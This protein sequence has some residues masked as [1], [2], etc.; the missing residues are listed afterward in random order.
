MSTLTG[1]A[2]I[3]ALLA[4]AT[5]AEELDRAR[6]LVDVE[7]RYGVAIEVLDR[8][9][10]DPDLARK[11]RI[12]AYRLL[13]VAY[14]AKGASDSAEAA[15]GALLELEPSYVLDPRLS[16]KIRSVFDRAKA[17]V[18]RPVRLLDVRALSS[19]RRVSVTARIE[20]PD[21]R[22]RRVRLY[23]RFGDRAFEA[24][25]MNRTEDRAETMLILPDLDRL[26]VEYYVEAENDAGEALARAGSPE[27]PSSV[28]LERQVDFTPPPPGTEPAVASPWYGEWW[29]WTIVAGV[30]G[31][32]VAA[33]VIAVETSKGGTPPSTL[34]PIRLE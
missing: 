26:R 30:V 14:A 21:H 15:F 32:G 29:V 10:Q 31:A 3:L 9:L 23:S 20:D 7:L 33:T 1:P 13:G 22:V 17:K 12:E 8:L 28:L 4:G 27:A 25:E 24:V 18:A 16:P 6:R 2:L 5:P 19:G 11:E 34:D